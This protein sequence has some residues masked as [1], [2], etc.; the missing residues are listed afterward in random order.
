MEQYVNNGDS[1]D[2][3][4]RADS[5]P[6]PNYQWEYM[7]RTTGTFEALERQTSSVLSLSSVEFDQYGRYRCVATANG[8]VESATSTS[9]LVTGKYTIYNYM[10]CQ[11]FL[12][13][14][15]GGVSVDPVLHTVDNGSNATFTC[16]VRGGPNNMIAW[17]RSVHSNILNNTVLLSEIS[18]IP[19]DTNAVVSIVSPFIIQNGSTLTISSINATQNG[20]EYLCVVVNEAGAESNS[21]SLY[22]RPLITTQPM[23][24]YVNDVQEDSV[25]L[26]CI[27][28]S[29]PAPTYQWQRMNATTE[30]FEDLSG[31]TNTTYIIT[32]VEHEDFGRYRCLV[33]TPTINVTINS[34]VALITGIYLIILYYYLFH[35]SISSWKCFC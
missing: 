20:G 6:A 3:S 35:F 31:E 14:P 24:Q 33:T 12:V 11:C 8:I 26:T 29:F 19:V 13:S 22:V 10:I 25:T 32:D 18:R 4:C 1:V 30:E 15:V 21:T 5:F 27:A 9:A 16:S 23:D 28:D 7:N 2:M 17:I 34:T